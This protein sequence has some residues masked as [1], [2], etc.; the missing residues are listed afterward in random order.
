MQLPPSIPVF[1]LPDHVLLPA[2]PTAYRIFE[3]RYRLLV[4]DLQS[5]P[6]DARWLVI[7]QL[8]AGWQEDYQGRP[9]F[10]AVSV[11]A[12]VRRIVGAGT[13]EFHIVVEGLVRCRFTELDSHKIYRLAR[14]ERLPDLI[15]ADCDLPQGLKEIL[16]QLVRL[17]SGFP[18]QALAQDPKLVEGVDPVML[19]DRLAAIVLSASAARQEWLECRYVS[20][21]LQILTDAIERLRRD[22]PP[23]RSSQWQ[24]S[25][26]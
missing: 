18:H 1:P 12:M 4:S 8:C 19:L 10:H 24:P 15:E 25:S 26:N 7:P 17:G 16:A 6:E 13:D 23:P 2:I 9:P 21:R 20:R 22:Q 14:P 11:A 5:Q 3:P